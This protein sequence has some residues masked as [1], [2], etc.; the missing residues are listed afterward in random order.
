MLP[1][2]WVDSGGVVSYQLILVF[3]V[4]VYTAGYRLFFLYRGRGLSM[5]ELVK[6]PQLGEGSIQFEFLQVL[7]GL[8]SFGRESR[9]DVE[10]LSLDFYQ[11]IHRYSGVL[12]TAVLLAPLLGLLGTVMG[13]IE[14]FSSLSDSSL[15]S[16]SGGIAGGISQAL[17]TT[18]MGLIVA[19]PGIF[20]S[21]YL[22][23]L[24][25]KTHSDLLQLGE[26]F[27]QQK[28]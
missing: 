27:I 4:I 28:G 25:K 5:R 19:V 21:R 14:T 11:E 24:E 3:F 23:Y 20:L 13:M 9:E 2:N 17:V 26:L 8:R 18:Q 12:G 22:K 10:Y 16:A 1:M 15:F 7:Q 6:N